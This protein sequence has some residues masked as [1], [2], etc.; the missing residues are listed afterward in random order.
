MK[1]EDKMSRPDDDNPTR[2][3][4]TWIIRP[5]RRVR[6][7]HDQMRLPLADIDDDVDLKKLSDA[8]FRA[9][10]VDDDDDL[11]ARFGDRPDPNPLGGFRQP[12]TEQE[13]R[14]LMEE[15]DRVVAEMLAE[16]DSGE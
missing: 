12:L 2:E 16:L 10:L 11:D 9:L 1:D 8:E 3:Q 7:H 5:R 13:S 4:G 6:K 15:L 14:E